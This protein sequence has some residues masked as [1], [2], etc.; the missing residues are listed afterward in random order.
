MDKF[1][2]Y[3]IDFNEAQFEALYDQNT[4]DE[5][6]DVFEDELSTLED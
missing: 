6:A 5:V 4:W 2:E 1:A 3:G